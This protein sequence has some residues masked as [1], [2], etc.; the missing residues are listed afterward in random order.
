MAKLALVAAFLKEFASENGF[1][2]HDRLHG[3]IDF[4]RPF[5]IE[6]S[7]A[8][9]YG[10]WVNSSGPP[11]EDVSEVPG[12]EGWYPVYWGKDIAPVS[13]LKAHVQ[14]HKNGNARLRSRDELKDRSLIFGAVI[15][16]RYTAFERMLH[17]R[18]RPL[19]GSSQGGRSTTV[20]RV[21]DD[22]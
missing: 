10:I 19:Y 18:F 8:S 11:R 17:S 14:N 20:V 21:L 12:H 7:S 2:T 3:S 15:V 6:Q 16:S 9:V 13:R 22:V 5:P 1:E 4:G